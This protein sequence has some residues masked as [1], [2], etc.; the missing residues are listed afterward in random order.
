MAGNGINESLVW[1]K[2]CR[3]PLN[4]RQTAFGTTTSVNRQA[5]SDPN[6]P[7]DSYHYMSDESLISVIEMYL[8][9]LS[10][11]VYHA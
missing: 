9:E 7:I 8:L 1:P 5:K 11:L 4:Y 2:T 10:R 6:Q 3:S